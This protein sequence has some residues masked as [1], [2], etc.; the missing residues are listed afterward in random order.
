MPVPAVPAARAGAGRAAAPRVDRWAQPG[1]G[2][3]SGPT[4]RS[5]TL[6][7]YLPIL[8]V[9][10]FAFNDTKR[11]RHVWDGLHASSG[12]RSRS[13]TRSSSKALLNSFLVAIP[14]A[15]LA[16]AFGTMA[17]LGLQRVAQARSRSCFDALTYMSI[18][19]PEIV[20]AL[21][22]L[23]LFAT[24]VRRHRVDARSGESS[25]S[26]A[27]DDHRGPRAVQHQPRAAARPGA[28]V[29]HGPDAG[30]GQRGPVRDAV[31][32]VPP[33]HV[34]A[35]AAGDRRRASCCRSRSAST[36]T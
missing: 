35:A 23:V 13:T 2:L 22:T 10:V 21:A 3:A 6:F 14:N 17:A 8:V 18:I 15:I 29:G 5:S 33:D 25:S 4:R 1:R 7:L 24:G 19:V 12:S 32:D 9:V 34:P 26:S 31:A 36:T 30:R 27:T 20:I 16:T 11:R 28:P